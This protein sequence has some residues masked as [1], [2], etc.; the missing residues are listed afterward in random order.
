MKFPKL[1]LQKRNS[2]LMLLMLLMLFLFAVVVYFLLTGDKMREG[3]SNNNSTLKA[4]KSLQKK[5]NQEI[6][7][8]LAASTTETE[9]AMQFE[10]LGKQFGYQDTVSKSI[11]L[12]GGSNMGSMFGSSDS[13]SDSDS[14]KSDSGKSDWL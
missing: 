13:D 1:G 14:G 8:K 7:K 12:L 9:V 5:G 2:L 6:K 10:W 4:L 11:K 3:V